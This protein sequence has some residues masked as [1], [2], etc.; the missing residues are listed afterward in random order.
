[1]SNKRPMV[2]FWAGFHGLQDYMNCHVKQ[3]YN[4]IT[5]ETKIIHILK[6]FATNVDQPRD[7]QHNK[8]PKAGRSKASVTK[9]SIP[10]TEQPAYL[11]HTAYHPRPRQL[12]R[13]LSFA[14]IPLTYASTTLERINRGTGRHL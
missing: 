11:C 12:F 13:R 7:T 14:L 2:D 8:Q 9:G 4:A 6:K 1:M 10:R 3:Q 5:G